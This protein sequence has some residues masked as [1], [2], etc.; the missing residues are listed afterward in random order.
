MIFR[1]P[2][3]LSHFLRL[4]SGL[5]RRLGD[6]ARVGVG[7]GRDIGVFAVARRF[8]VVV[9]GSGDL[10]S[11]FLEGLALGLGDE[12]GGEDAAQHEQGEDLHDVVEP[13]GGVF[14]CWVA[15]GSQ[16]PEHDLRDD[17]ADLAGRRGDAVR[18][19]AVAGRE[20]FAGHDEGRRV[21]SEVEEEL[22]EHVECEQAVFGQVVVC[23]ADDDEEDGQDG[24]AHQLDGFP[25]DGVD[26]GDGDPVAGDGAGADDDQVANGRVAEDAVDVVTLG[27][28]DCAQNNGVIETKTVEGNIEEEPRSGRSNEDLAVSPLAVVAPD[29]KR[30]RIRMCGFE[31]KGRE[32]LQSAQLALGAANRSRES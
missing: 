20:A 12:K 30:S 4:H 1:V 17:G 23:E 24:E 2:S 10:A 11:E 25:A 8:G 5:L 15:L 28:A 26:G 13:R 18:G 14:G 29:W 9:G 16:G 27:V 32:Y 22:A 31:N 3:D 7:G 6:L 21:G 19:R